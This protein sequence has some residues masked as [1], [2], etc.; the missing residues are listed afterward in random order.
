MDIIFIMGLVISGLFLLFHYFDY[1]C[2][3]KWF[4]IWVAILSWFIFARVHLTS[5]ITKHEFNN[6]EINGKLSHQIVDDNVNITKL[7]GTLGDPETQ[8]VEITQHH[9][10]SYGIY[11]IMVG[12]ENNPSGKTYRFIKKEN[13]INE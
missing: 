10:W 2:N 8:L 13:K 11:F 1:G 5:I 9:N 6:V 3:N 4:F 12:G 7:I